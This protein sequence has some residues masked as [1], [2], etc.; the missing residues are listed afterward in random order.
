MNN[1][2]KAGI[3]S[4]LV[5]GIIAGI[6][7]TILTPIISVKYGELVF[8]F[9]FR[10]YMPTI[11]WFAVPPMTPVVI[12]AII[13]MMVALVWGVILGIIYMKCYSSIPGNGI[14]KG[15]IYGLFF[16]LILG[17]RVAIGKYIIYANIH[18]AVPWIIA[19]FPKWITYGLVLGII[20]EFM[21]RRYRVPKE[22]LKIKI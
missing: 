20:Y 7:A 4:G 11:F 17:I 12:I 15:L 19:G 10:L 1:N 6:V 5:A 21:Q 14:L 3:I 16:H 2:L 13:E 9:A 18:E 22:E 8:P